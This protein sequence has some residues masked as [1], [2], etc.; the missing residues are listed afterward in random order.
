MHCISVYIFQLVIINSLW[1]NTAPDHTER[2]G[3]VQC[4]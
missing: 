2:P 4:G 3:A 1:W